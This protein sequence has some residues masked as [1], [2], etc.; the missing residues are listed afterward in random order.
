MRN[1]FKYILIFLLIT[2]AFI[3][4]LTLVNKFVF[5]PTIYN[6]KYFS[7]DEKTFIM[8]DSH[9]QCAIDPDIIED[10]VNLSKN[11]ENYFLTYVKLTYFLKYSKPERVLLNFSYHNFST[12]YDEEMLG[13]R[14]NVLLNR[15]YP[16]ISDQE[17]IFTSKKDGD[18]LYTKLK[19]DW[20]LPF[21]FSNNMHLFFYLM[22]N[23]KP[24]IANY[25]FGGYYRYNDT[26]NLSNDT[27][28]Q[29]LKAHYDSD[30]AKAG[31]SEL[32]YSYVKKICSMCNEN[33]IEIILINT[34]VHDDYYNKIPDAFKRNHVVVYDHLKQE[35][36]AKY[37]DFSRFPLPDKGFGDGDHLN[38]LGAKLFSEELS[39]NLKL[40]EE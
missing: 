9:T 5:L 39:K 18:W 17:N 29:S 34:P 24:D 40:M 3:I 14:R 2:S 28:Q 21:D 10:S 8:G 31:I 11:S 16:I 38:A 32:M 37:L 12:L 30:G 35:F 4:G 1:I 33:N 6:P 19:Y 22:H 26:C 20:G 13:V 23:G 15:Y 27:I 25:P 36:N 7:L